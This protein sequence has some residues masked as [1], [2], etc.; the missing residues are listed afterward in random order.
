LYNR[1]KFIDADLPDAKYPLSVQEM[2][3]MLEED[4]YVKKINSL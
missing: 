2:E 4:I 3:S 1:G